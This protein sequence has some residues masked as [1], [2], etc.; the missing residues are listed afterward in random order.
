M[1]ISEGQ[2][3]KAGNQYSDVIIA[4]SNVISPKAGEYLIGLSRYFETNS[5]I[6][7]IY[8]IVPSMESVP[9]DS[10]LINAIHEKG[11]DS[12]GKTVLF[13]ISCRERS[14]G[15]WTGRILEGLI[16]ERTRNDILNRKMRPALM[17]GHFEKALLIGTKSVASILAEKIRLDMS[18]FPDIRSTKGKHQSSTGSKTVRVTVNA[19]GI[20]S[21]S[22]LLVLVFSQLTK[23]FLRPLNPPSRKAP[24]FG[25]RIRRK[26]F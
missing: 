6:R 12:A 19:A 21:L 11:I 16:N 8:F 3:G 5:G 20:I 15:L 17:R 7:F 23:L 22:L 18:A 1:M 13:L 2:A 4:Q 10:F 25:R 26:G 24:G 9:M 14:A